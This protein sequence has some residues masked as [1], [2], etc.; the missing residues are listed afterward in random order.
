LLAITRPTASTGFGSR[1]T[2]PWQVADIGVEHP[3]NAP[4]D[5]YVT[6]ED[7]TG[8]TATVVN[9]DRAAVNSV[10][11]TEWRI[12]LQNFIDIDLNKI[13]K[14]TIGVGGRVDATLTGDGHVYIDDIWVW[15]P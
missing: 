12:P 8:Q 6:V 10:N 13:R 9:P 7:S 14:M 2:G 15:K 1:V 11:W 5:L 3:G 4:D